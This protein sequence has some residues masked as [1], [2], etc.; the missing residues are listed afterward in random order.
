MVSRCRSSRRIQV[1]VEHVCCQSGVNEGGSFDLGD[2]RIIGAVGSA[3]DPINWLLVVGSAFPPNADLAWGE[4]GGGCAGRA[5]R[6]GL[7]KLV[8]IVEVT[9]DV[10]P[11]GDCK[12]AIVQ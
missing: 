3:L 11:L 10:V 1:I 12:H 7:N 6:D 4:G 9:V 5:L 2:L 8:A